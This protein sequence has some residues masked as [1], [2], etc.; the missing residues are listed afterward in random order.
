MAVDRSTWTDRRTW[1][2]WNDELTGMG[3]LVTPDLDGL[4]VG[5]ARAAWRSTIFGPV[6]P[7]TGHDDEAVTAIATGDQLHGGELF[8]SV[9]AGVAL[10]L[11]TATYTPDP[12]ALA[13]NFVVTPA[14]DALV[15][16]GGFRLYVWSDD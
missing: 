10:Y 16:P 4:T 7:G 6:L 13:H 9:A 5:Q 1:L 15:T 2:L 3:W 14:A 11:T 12:G 8:H